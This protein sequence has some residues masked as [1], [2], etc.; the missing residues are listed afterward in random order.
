VSS[1]SLS[2]ETR[3][4]LLRLARAAIEARLRGEP[5]P[6]LVSDRA[7][8]FGEARGVFVTLTKS[9]S[10]RGCIGTLAPEGDLS[11]VV[12]R[13]A[14]HAAFEDPRFP[15]VDA[16]ELAG[17]RI[18]ISVLTAPLG[19]ER[20]E[21]IEIGRHGLILEAG[22]HRGLLLPQVATHWGFDRETFLAEL[23]KKAGLPPDAWRQPGVR[24][25]TFE[26][27]VF[28]E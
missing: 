21:Q 2:E 4:G 26:A 13:Y 7:E 23:S 22:R 28:E 9:G 19:V 12:P 25:W 8:A 18:E 5:P 16:E 24:L 11:R 10:L 27:E 17:C 15:P 1:G 3:R 14:V 6:R 20:P